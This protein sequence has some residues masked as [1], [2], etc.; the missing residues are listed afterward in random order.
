[1]KAFNL[2]R[3][4]VLMSR[5]DKKVTSKI[6][7]LI[8]KSMDRIN[9]HLHTLL[10]FVLQSFISLIRVVRPDIPSRRVKIGPNQRT[11]RT[12]NTVV[13]PHER[14]K[15]QKP[16]SIR[17]IFYFPECLAAFVRGIANTWCEWKETEEKD[18]KSQNSNPD[19]EKLEFRHK[20]SKKYH[21]FSLTL[22]LSKILPVALSLQLAMSIY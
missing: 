20:I 15:K 19:Q 12:S 3:L 2:S 1:M 8:K 9:F 21:Y 16:E 11:I 4:S 22:C 7:L 5:W 13:K 10:N 17:K 14:N 6:Q 18:T